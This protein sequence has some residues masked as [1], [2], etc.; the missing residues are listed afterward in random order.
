MDGYAQQLSARGE[1]VLEKAEI[2]TDEVTGEISLAAPK[3]LNLAIPY[4]K[5]WSAFVDGRKV[6]LYRSNVMYMALDLDAGR[7]TVRL[8]YH[9]P[10]LK[11]GMYISVFTG[12]ACLCAALIRKFRRK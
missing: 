1:T 9:T 5:G 3:L 11:E 10:W 8:T 2:G 6:K 4:S 12:L 7:H